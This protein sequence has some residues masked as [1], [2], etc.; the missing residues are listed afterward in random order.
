MT[1]KTSTKSAT[2]AKAEIADPIMDKDWTY[3]QSKA[4]SELHNGLAQFITD[5]AGI[6][7]DPKQVQ[8]LLAMHGAWQKSGLN[9][10]RPDYRPRT[11][12]SIAKGGATMAERFAPEPEKPAPARRGRSAKPAVPVEA[13][14]ATTPRTRKA[15]VKADA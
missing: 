10:S 3:L 1:A 13:K 6:D 9:K 15:A 11:Q 2:P 4:P 5:Q 7:I 12:E 8:A 14:K